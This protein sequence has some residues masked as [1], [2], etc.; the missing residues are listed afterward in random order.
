M[1]VVLYIILMQTVVMA[2]LEW[3]HVCVLSSSHYLLQSSYP[4][5]AFQHSR[6]TQHRGK[7]GEGASEAAI[8][9]LK[10]ECYD[11]SCETVGASSLH[12]KAFRV[13]DG[14]EQLFSQ[15]PP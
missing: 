7:M 15:L 1:D 14:Y 5:S 8:G 10:Y 3:C 9:G 11:R 2:M 4:Y 13:V 6:Q 12:P